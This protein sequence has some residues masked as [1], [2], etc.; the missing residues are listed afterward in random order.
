M[1]PDRHYYCFFFFQG[2]H[3]EEIHQHSLSSKIQSEVQQPTGLPIQTTVASSVFDELTTHFARGS[4]GDSAL[5]TQLLDTHKA[6]TVMH[7]LEYL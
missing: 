5:F 7:T 2:Q 6:N 3:P 4:Q 1:K